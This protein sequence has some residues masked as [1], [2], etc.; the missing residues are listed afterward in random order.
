M[1]TP[2]VRVSRR[3][4]TLTLGSGLL[5]ASRT[6]NITL[7]DS[8]KPEPLRKICSGVDEMKARLDTAGEAMGSDRLTVL[9]DPSMTACSESEVCTAPQPMSRYWSVTLAVVAVNLAGDSVALPAV[10]QA[11]DTVTWTGEPTLAPL[12]P[13]VKLVWP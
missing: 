1:V 7:D 2:P 4:V 8:V 6:S 13:T 3:K 10:T 9:A 12:K 11:D 5:L